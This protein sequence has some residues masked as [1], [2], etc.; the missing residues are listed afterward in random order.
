MQYERQGDRTDPAG[1]ANVLLG[2]VRSSYANRPDRNNYAATA[3]II[4]NYTQLPTA[5]CAVPPR[6]RPRTTNRPRPLHNLRLSLGPMHGISELFGN[7]ASARKNDRC[8]VRGTMFIVL[9]TILIN[10]FTSRVGM[11]KIDAE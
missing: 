8:V 1:A 2:T 7:G 3:A 6:P 5:A 4:S 9:I 10:A 11:N